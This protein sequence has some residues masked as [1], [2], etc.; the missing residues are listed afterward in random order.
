MPSPST[1]T[2]PRKSYPFVAVNC[3]AIP[4]NL[5]ESELFGYEEGSFTG[6]SKGG[7]PG[8]FEHASHGTIF[9]DEIG[10][11]S[12]NLQTR[13]LRVIQEKQIMRVGSGK[14]VDIDARIIAAT[15]A[16]L[17]KTVAKGDFRED[18]FY[19]LNVIPLSIAPLRQS[20]RYTAA[21]EGLSRQTVWIL[22]PSDSLYAH[23]TTA[24]PGNVRELENAAHISGP[25]DRSPAIFRA[26]VPAT[27]PMTVSAGRISHV[28]ALPPSDSQ[29][30]SRDLRVAIL[31]AVGQNSTPFSG[32]GRGSSWRNF[33]R[34]AFLLGE[35]ILKRYLSE[36]KQDGLI[37]SASGRSAQ[38]SP[39]RAKKCSSRKCNEKGPQHGCLLRLF[40]PAWEAPLL[41]IQKSDFTVIL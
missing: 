1:T 39:K 29:K 25:W 22:S 30:D 21:A 27:S 20:G 23:G 32:I 26:S 7:K 35:G 14:I 28:M 36:L 37:Y 16:D 11:I 12:P 17:E 38:D 33:L 41:F 19:R 5:L 13:L 34:R 40:I 31:A 6:A 24:G 4:E 18:L 2:L 3:A 9:L 8:L 15:N 10:D